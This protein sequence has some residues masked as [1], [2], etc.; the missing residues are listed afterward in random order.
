MQGTTNP[1]MVG[2]DKL[3]QLGKMYHKLFKDF[4]AAI[5]CLEHAQRIYAKDK[6]TEHMQALPMHFLGDLYLDL[7]DYR[8]A[9]QHLDRCIQICEDHS[10][11]PKMQQAFVMAYSG[12]GRCLLKE[13][14]YKQACS[15]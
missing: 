9:H 11:D 4:R 6:T 8:K 15:P 1:T 14:K 7:R 10:S 5:S 2:A 12:L 13:G 3:L